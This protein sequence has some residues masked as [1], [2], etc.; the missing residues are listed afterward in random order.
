MFASRGQVRSLGEK[1][2][3]RIAELIL[4]CHFSALSSNFNWVANGC[5]Q[6]VIDAPLNQLIRNTSSQS[7]I[8]GLRNTVRWNKR[9]VC[10][11][12]SNFRILA[13]HQNLVLPAIATFLSKSRSTPFR[14]AEK[15]YGN[16]EL[17]RADLSIFALVHSSH[18]PPR[19]SQRI[20]AGRINDQWRRRA[21]CEKSFSSSARSGPWQSTSG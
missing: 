11:Y 17:F 19:C 16:H 18:K 5:F 14:I 7:S 12:R 1:G 6:H 21:C 10:S 9:G 20:P 8:E 15:P 3:I 2:E 13:W 4:R